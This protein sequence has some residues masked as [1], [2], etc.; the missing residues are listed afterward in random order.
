ME[1]LKKEI[2]KI[3]KNKKILGI[4]LFGSYASGNQ[5][6]NSDIDICIIGRLNEND[7]NKIFRELPEKFDISFFDE[8][9]IYIKFRVFKEGKELFTR[10]EKKLDLIKLMTLREYRD[11]KP[12]ME[13]RAKEMFGNVW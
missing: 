1:T 12:L 6:P 8:L 5:R 9:P 7:K 11:F 2:E 10:D 3:K 13:R 4:Y